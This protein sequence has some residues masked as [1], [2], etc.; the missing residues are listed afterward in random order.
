[1]AAYVSTGVLCRDTA[2]HCK[3]ECIALANKWHT[4][5]YR[6]GLAVKYGRIWQSRLGAVDKY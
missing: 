4:T 2:T 5:A 1:M 3:F 6:P